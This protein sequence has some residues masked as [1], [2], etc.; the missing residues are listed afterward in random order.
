MSTFSEIQQAII[1]LPESEFIQ[2]REWFSE[3]DWQRWN[4]RIEADAEEGKLDFLVDQAMKAKS[5]GTLL[6]L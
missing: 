6:D 5:E 2:L 1:A 3:L 4:D